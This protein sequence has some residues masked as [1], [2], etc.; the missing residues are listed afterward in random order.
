MRV[1]CTRDALYPGGMSGV[2]ARFVENA[3]VFQQDLAELVLSANSIQVDPAVPNDCTVSSSGKTN[4]RSM[5]TW[6]GRL[7]QNWLDV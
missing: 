5:L 3:L 2:Q 4:E 7:R 6:F 1:V